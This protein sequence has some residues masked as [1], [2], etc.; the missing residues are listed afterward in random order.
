MARLNYIDNLL[1]RGIFTRQGRG[2]PVDLQAIIETNN[3]DTPERFVDYF[4]AF[5]LD[6]VIDQNRRTQ[7][8]DYLTTKD[9]SRGNAHIT[10]KNGQSYP[11]NR[12]RGTLYLMMALPEY[13]LN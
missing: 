11:L 13:Q 2:N 3:I 8:I 6:G 4:A 10:L 12:V 5:L 9:R 1:A 7:L